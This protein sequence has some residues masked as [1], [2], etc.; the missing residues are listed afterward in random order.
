ME[1][2]TALPTEEQTAAPTPVDGG[3]GSGLGGGDA[4]SG[5]DEVDWRSLALGA[6]LASLFICCLFWILIFIFWKKRN[7]VSTDESA[8]TQMTSTGAEAGV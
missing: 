2:T 3:D 4:S 8:M 7:E 5:F 6:I 1:P